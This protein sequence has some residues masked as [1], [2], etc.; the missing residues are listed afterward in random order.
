MR[1]VGDIHERLVAR[2]NLWAAWLDFQRGK[3]GRPGV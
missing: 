3:R 2:D 1:R